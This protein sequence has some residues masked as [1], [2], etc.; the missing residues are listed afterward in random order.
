MSGYEKWTYFDIFKCNNCDSHFIDENQIDYSIYDKIYSNEDKLPWYSRYSR[1]FKEIK[2]SK[3]KLDYLC[4]EES[5]PL[6]IKTYLKSLKKDK[7][8]IKILEVWCWLW[9]TTYALNEE[10]YKCIGMDISENSVKKAKKNFGDYYFVWDANKLWNYWEYRWKYDIVYST[11][12]IEHISNISQ[13]IDN[14]LKLINPWWVLIL[15]TP[16]KDY[17]PKWCIWFS[18]VPPVHTCLIWS[19]FFREY[20]QKNI[21]KLKIFNYNTNRLDKNLLLDMLFEKKWLKN[22]EKY[23]RQDRIDFN[24]LQPVHKINNSIKSRIFKFLL[25]NQICCFVSNLFIRLFLF[26]LESRTLWVIMSK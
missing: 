23:L 20:C 1:Y 3:N 6:I 11:E 9:Y 14:M 24:N 13:F 22:S 18:D 12:V 10:W 21:L 16:N 8:N 17:M 25:K 2:K 19:K 26:K 5:I 7:G 4:K 15:T